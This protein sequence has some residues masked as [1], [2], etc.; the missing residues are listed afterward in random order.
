VADERIVSSIKIVDP[1]TT[2][3]IAAVDASSNLQVILAAN[4]GVDIGDVDVTSVIPGTGATNLGKAV[5][6]V[7]GAT[8][9][10]VAVLAVRDDALG[11]ITPA[12]GDYNTLL[13]DANG[14]LWTHDDALDATIAGNELQVDVVAALPTGANTIGDIANITTTV[15]PGTAA[16]NLGKAVDAV[17]GATDTG[18]AMLAVR[19]DALGGI[20]PAA[21]DYST[22][23]MD[24]NGALWTHDD[25]LDVAIAG[26]ELQVDVVAALPT[27]ANTIGSIADITTSVTPGTAAGNLGK[28]ED[29]VHGSGDTGVMALAVRQDTATALAADADYIPLI[30]DSTGR[31][32]V[33]DANAGAGTPTNPTVDVATSSA[34][35]AGSAVDLD[36]AEITEA[37]KLYGVDITASVPFKAIVRMV[38]NSIDNANH[39]VVFGQAGEL[40]QWR[41]AH[42]DFFTHAGASG[43]TDLFQVDITNMDTSEAADVYASF[44]YASS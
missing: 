23:L 44:M 43:G 6:A 3:Q 30:V 22:L 35:A 9:T 7:A 21:G 13:I 36:S 1:T 20:T 42:K 11:G 38:E 40:V 17:A 24:A 18:V 32:H 26:N 31:L 27:G 5:D 28:A 29:A 14:A 8:D 2:S 25:A 19:D 16:G 34:L 41:P 10:G 39:V 12:A 4:D 37:E 15:T 33:T